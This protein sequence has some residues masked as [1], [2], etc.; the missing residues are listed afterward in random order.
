MV[1]GIINILVDGMKDFG[2]MLK[3]MVKENNNSFQEM[4]IK[5]IGLKP[6]KMD[7]VINIKFLE[8]F[9]KEIGVV[10]YL[11]EKV[12]NIGHQQVTHKM[13]NGQIIIDMV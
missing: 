10:I 13:E 3:G 11:M 8:I 2:E 9:K 5:V 1:M 12:N 4:F 6:K 7:R